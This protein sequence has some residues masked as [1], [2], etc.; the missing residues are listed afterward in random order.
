MTRRS[1]AQLDLFAQ[2]Q[3]DLFAQPMRTALAPVVPP[4]MAPPPCFCVRCNTKGKAEALWHHDGLGGTICYPCLTVTEPECS[5]C[6][7]LFVDSRGMA[8]T[9]RFVLPTGR[10][11]CWDCNENRRTNQPQAELTADE[12]TPDALATFDALEWRD[13]THRFRAL[14]RL[15]ASLEALR[16]GGYTPKEQKAAKS[17]KLD[18][19]HITY[20]WKVSRA[21][22]LAEIA[23]EAWQLLDAYDQAK[24]AGNHEYDPQLWAQLDLLNNEANNGTSFGVRVN[25]GPKR[26]MKALRVRARAESRLPMW[27]IPSRFRFECRGMHVL[28]DTNGLSMRL[29]ADRHRPG[30]LSFSG[31]GYRSFQPCSRPITSIAVTTPE[32]W[33]RGVLEAYIDGPTKDG[34][35]RG[36]KL[37]RWIPWEAEQW[38][39][40][41][42]D[43][44][45][46]E[47]AQE[48]GR[49]CWQ[50]RKMPEY[51]AQE[52]KALAWMQLRGIDPFA[53]FPDEVP[54]AQAA[55]L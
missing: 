11:V 31:T 24:R 1:A 16:K 5:D 8:N 39:R 2:H 49:D 38:I 35:G 48:E 15:R 9:R 22:P 42:T 21:R 47:A 33:A 20:Q 30:D 41:R 19:D 50:T 29:D 32:E 28:A 43:R 7:A 14:Y 4:Y 40:A 12:A 55:L 52:A 23:D 53:L 44:R 3:G 36:G 25:R 17:A 10:G 37:E 45:L 34:A 51:D 54:P 13:D 46:G 6:R 26:L 18:P 27:G